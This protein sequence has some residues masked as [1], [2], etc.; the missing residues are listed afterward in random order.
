M[1]KIIERHHLESFLS[2]DNI[3][4]PVI[5]INDIETPDFELILPEAKISIEHTRVI[6][7]LKQ[8][9]EAYQNKIILEAKK[10]FNSLYSEE[11]YV[12]ITFNEFEFKSGAIAFEVYVNEVFEVVEKIFI[13]NQN[14][15]FE[16]EDKFSG[17]DISPS[18]AR[19]SVTNKMK[20]NHW[21]SFS[22]YFV[23]NFNSNSI[24]KQILKKQNNIKK[25][26]NTY[27]E[28]WLLLISELGS[29][30]SA[31]TLV[32]KDFEEFETLFDRVYMY[33]YITKELS[34]IK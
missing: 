6:Y 10:R 32:T 15:I 28:N 27:S 34:V 19:I 18:I 11:L 24:K 22:A 23:P 30:A 26:Q 5:T 21:Q 7:P 1:K 12:L 3:K 9:R 25:Y 13:N 8:Q 33:G 20:F 29:E 31:G 16:I 2:H 4:V 14:F 17:K